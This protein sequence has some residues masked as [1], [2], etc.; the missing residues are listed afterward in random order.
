M[1]SHSDSLSYSR[2]NHVI[3]M[4]PLIIAGCSFSDSSGSISDST[5]SII[6]SPSSISDK[7][8]KYENEVSDYTMA[9]V[10]SSDVDYNSFLKGLSDIAAKRGIVNWDQEPKTY[11]AIG[12]GL[13]RAGSQGI[14]Y[15]TYKMNFAHSDEKKMQNIQKGYESEK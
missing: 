5:S 2:F 14:A 7:D 12:K 9:Y 4:L 13:K 15:E 3:L 10:K 8:K 1:H 6:S 11:V